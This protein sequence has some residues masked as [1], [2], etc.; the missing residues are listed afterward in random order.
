MIIM[1]TTRCAYH[2]DASSFR[3]TTEEPCTYCT[4]TENMAQAYQD[5]RAMAERDEAAYLARMETQADRAAF[6]DSVI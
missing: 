5:I 2:F 1:G 3:N 6:R 4:D